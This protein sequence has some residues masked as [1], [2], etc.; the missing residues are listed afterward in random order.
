MEVATVMW[1]PDDAFISSALT[2]TVARDLFF[3]ITDGVIGSGTARTVYSYTVHPEYVLKVET[4]SGSFQNA[5]EWKTWQELK[6]TDLGKWLA[7]IHSISPCGLYLLQRRTRRP[8]D[9]KYPAK[10]PAFLTDQKRDNYGVL[11]SGRFVCHDYGTC[12]QF[13][14]QPG[15]LVKADWWE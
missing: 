11:P 5:M 13:I 2:T 14:N 1:N 3:Y 4:G 9:S 12:L 6:D 7:P 15:R 10:L 8:L